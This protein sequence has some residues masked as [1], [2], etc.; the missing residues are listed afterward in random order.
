[1]SKPQKRQRR[2]ETDTY[3]ACEY[4]CSVP[5]VGMGPSGI[6]TEEDISAFVKK[7][8]GKVPF[9][10]WEKHIYPL[11]RVGLKDAFFSGCT[12]YTG[13]G[14][15]DIHMDPIDGFEMLRLIQQNPDYHS[16]PV[17]ALTASVMNEEVRKLR[18]C[19]FDGVIAKPLDYDTFPHAL[20]RIL[21]GE[22]VWKI[23]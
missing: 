9:A 17:V 11:N 22:Q 23:K 3:D 15:L 12:F 2:E 1:M 6:V 20:T 18:E 19:G 10:V 16:I 21:N 4:G 13:H 7:T 8:D 5:H 14:K